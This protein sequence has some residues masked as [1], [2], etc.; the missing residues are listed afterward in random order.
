MTVVKLKAEPTH[1]L[2]NN[3]MDNFF[4]TNPSMFRDDL[5]LNSVKSTVP[6][7]V[8]EKEDYYQ[9]Q[10]VAPGLQ[11]EDFSINLDKSLLTVSAEVRND[12]EQKDVK[13]VRKEYKFQSFKRSFTID[14]K[15]DAEKISAEYVNGVLLLNLPKKAEVKPAAKQISVQ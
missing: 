11:K 7:N 14:E 4:Q 12:T 1:R 13:L 3:F 9:L 5:E 10:V 15:I 2:F 8:E 6:V